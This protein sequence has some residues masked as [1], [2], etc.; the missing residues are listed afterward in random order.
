MLPKYFKKYYFAL[1]D[2]Y[3][4]FLNNFDEIEEEQG[5]LVKIRNVIL[6]HRIK[7]LS[8]LSYYLVDTFFAFN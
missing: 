2:M 4:I 7:S 1:K 8:I 5:S 6:W 3:N